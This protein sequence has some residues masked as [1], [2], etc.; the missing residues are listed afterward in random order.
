MK[1]LKMQVNYKKIYIYIPDKLLEYITIMDGIKYIKQRTR[2]AVLNNEN[3]NEYNYITHISYITSRIPVNEFII[4][5]LNHKEFI[6]EERDIKGRKIYK[7]ETEQI[8]LF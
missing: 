5:R 3:N 6:I 8:P 2:I 7:E 1:T 4:K